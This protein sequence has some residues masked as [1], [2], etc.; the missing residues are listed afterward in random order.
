MSTNATSSVIEEVYAYQDS[1]LDPS[2]KPKAESGRKLTPM[3]Y[4]FMWIG[5]GV[6]LGNM[7]LGA[8]LVVAGTAVLNLFQTFVAAIIA[9][10]IISTFLY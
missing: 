2:L 3:S 6:N 9:I 7:T 8:S 1:G 5:D 10:G 4:M